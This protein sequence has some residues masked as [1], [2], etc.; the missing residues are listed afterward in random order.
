MLLVNDVYSYGRR[1]FRILWRNADLAYWIDIDSKN[2]LPEPIKLADLT[3][4]LENQSIR[5]IPDPHEGF[6]LSPPSQRLDWGKKVQAEAWAMISLYVQQEP[7]IYLRAERGKMIQVMM[8]AHETTKQTVYAKLRCYWQKGKSPKCLFPDTRKNGGA[9]KTKAAGLKKLGRPRTV[10]IGLGVNISEQIAAI[11]R[12]V[13]KAFYTTKQN[14]TLDFAYNKALVAMGIDRKKVTEEELAEVPTYHQFYHFMRKETGAVERARKRMGEI[15]YLKDMRPVLGTSAAGVM[16]PGSLYQIDAT[17][18]DVYLLSE[19]DRSKIVGR[20]TLYIVIDV[21]SRLITGIYVGFE[22][23]SW[24]S[25]MGALANALVDKVAYCASHGIEITRDEWPVIGKPEAILGDRGEMLG[26]TVEIV[27]EAL[28]IDIQNTPPY[29]A[30]WKGVVERQFN[31]IQAKFKPY[32]AGYVTGDIGKKRAG[33][34]YRLDAELTLSEFTK[35]IIACV[36]EYNT[37]HVIES[38]DADK[39]MP[40]ELPHNPLLLW[41]WG[42]SNR[43]GKLRGVS[44]DLALVN[45]LPH[46]EATVSEEGI[47]L[48]GCKYSTAMAIKDGWFDRINAGPKKVL[49]AYHPYS[50]NKIYLRPSGKYDSFIICE[51]TERSREFRDLTFWDVWRI[52]AIKRKTMSKAKL[53]KRKGRLGLDE[54]IEEITNAAR[55]KNPNMSG[56]SKASRLTGIR[57]NRANELT[58]Q[59]GKQPKLLT[60]KEPSKPKENNVTYLNR[61]KPK[62]F[63]VPDMLDDLFDSDD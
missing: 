56:E 2:A 50:T 62:S 17:I 55:A 35:V 13:L 23:P 60:S 47:D 39:D 36:L 3:S 53:T 5:Y 41:N 63:D 52:T 46:K 44:Q 29:R 28:N 43:T 26:H 22:P 51:L 40:P 6:V 42:I 16:G 7:D 25:A 27:S 37:T 57:D 4:L 10:S 59:R 8:A 32:V 14:N 45:L 1:S 9:G 24:V 18:A 21:F 48:F 54:T 31:T 20:P 33:N 58:E 61:E 15:Q 11:F 49:V 19:S 30:D 12:A 38:Y 34:D